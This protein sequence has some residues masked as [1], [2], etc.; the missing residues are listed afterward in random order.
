[1]FNLLPAQQREG[2][3]VFFFLLNAVIH[4]DMVRGPVVSL[5][6]FLPFFFFFF[7]FSINKY[8]SK[9]RKLSSAYKPETVVYSLILHLGSFVAARRR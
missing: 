9:I 7:F 8:V 5:R 3:L 4:S 1:M 6:F 2:H